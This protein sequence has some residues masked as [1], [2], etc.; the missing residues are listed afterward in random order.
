[1]AV[2]MICSEA[3]GVCRCLPL[4]YMPL[5]G[6]VNARSQQAGVD[7]IGLRVKVCLC[8]ND[9]E[10]VVNFLGIICGGRGKVSI[11]IGCKSV[12]Y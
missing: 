4:R 7:G 1:M 11:S 12:I 3:D 8:H 10:L 9:L 5:S 2:C 6:F